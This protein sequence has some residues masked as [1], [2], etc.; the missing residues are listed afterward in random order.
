[1][2]YKRNTSKKKKT[3]NPYV[4]P[5]EILNRKRKGPSFLTAC[6]SYT[7]AI[8]QNISMKKKKKLGF[9]KHEQIFIY[10]NIIFLTRAKSHTQHQS[11][12]L[13]RPL[14]LNKDQFKNLSST[15]ITF[16]KNPYTLNGKNLTFP[17]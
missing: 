9:Y 14:L 2:S 5:C 12:I 16:L 13:D 11:S 8:K 15:N 10:I 3:S 17:N 4:S 7:P 1:M 6:S